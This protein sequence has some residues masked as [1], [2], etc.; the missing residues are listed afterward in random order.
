MD[1]SFLTENMKHQL[2]RRFPKVE[3]SYD[4][5]LH[6]MVCDD[7]YTIIPKGLK[8]FMWLTYIGNK[9]VCILLTLNH[10]GNVKSVEVC[11][12]SFDKTLSHGTVIYGTLFRVDGQL[13]FTFENIYYLKGRDI[14]KMSYINKLAICCDMF[15][16]ELSQNAY[17]RTSVIPG[18]PVI[19]RNFKSAEEKIDSLMYPVYGI[20]VHNKKMRKGII[21]THK[22][23]KRFANFIV[24]A[25]QQDDIY[26]LYAKDKYNEN[27]FYGTAMISTYTDSVM[28]N[29]LFRNIKENNNLD[30]LEESDSDEDFEN[31]AEDKFVDLDKKLVMRCE[32][33]KKFRKWRPLV[34]V[35]KATIVTGKA[36]IVT[37]KHA[38]IMEKNM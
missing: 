17:T 25:A 31:V 1:K 5:I 19:C 32:Y 33:V 2:M 7:Y 11:H 13:F 18:M 36:T 6:K 26:H 14:S 8:A 21:L 23:Q 29:S 4:K 28:M 30:F 16:D 27:T 12:M 10:R 35:G 37:V 3:L 9:N 24:C 20:Q 34:V 38:F 22:Q 15:S